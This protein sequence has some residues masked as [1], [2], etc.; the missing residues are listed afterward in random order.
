MKLS[1]LCAFA[2]CAVI[3]AHAAPDTSH[4]QS[5]T[6][7]YKGYDISSLLSEEEHGISYKDT[8]RGNI[9]RP[10]EHIL[11]DGGMNSARLRYSNQIL[12]TKYTIYRR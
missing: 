6:T 2:L 12:L 5:G 9:T 4:S 10:L 7:F 11:G 3:P 1:N 8:A